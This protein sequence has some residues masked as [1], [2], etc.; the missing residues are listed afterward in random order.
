MYIMLVQFSIYVY[1]IKRQNIK[2]PRN[3]PIGLCIMRKPATDVA[4]LMAERQNAII[5]YDLAIHVASY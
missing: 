3:G 5:V 4:I 2:L 1:W